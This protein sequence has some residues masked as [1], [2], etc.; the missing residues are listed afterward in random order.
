[1]LYMLT[2]TSSALEC[3]NQLIPTMTYIKAALSSC[4]LLI[5]TNSVYHVTKKLE[6]TNPQL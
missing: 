1:M 2:F 6:S 3:Q 5:N 4:F